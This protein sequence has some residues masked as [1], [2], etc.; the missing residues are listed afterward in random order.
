[1]AGHNQPEKS[2]V[3]PGMSILLE[4]ILAR[5]DSFPLERFAQMETEIH[6]LKAMAAEDVEVR[7]R[8]SD[9]L[10][11][12]SMGLHDAI[13]SQLDRSFDACKEDRDLHL[14]RMSDRV[15]AIEGTHSIQRQW[16]DRVKVVLISAGC[17]SL[18]S[19]ITAVVNWLLLH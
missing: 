16:G 6:H 19:A 9:E 17:A 11:K 1:M 7:C 3:E 15:T 14:Q 10:R 18:V 4:R 8:L 13:E 5:L 2:N 12:L